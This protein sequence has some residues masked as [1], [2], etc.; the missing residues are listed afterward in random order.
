MQRLKL[1]LFIALAACFF[2]TPGLLLGQGASGEP[3]APFVKAVEV[4]GNKAISSE[5]ILARIKTRAG[6]PYY[7]QSGRDDI[8]RLY[9]TGYFSDISIDI[10]E[11]ADGLRVIF[12]VEERPTIQEVTIKGV[13]RVS[14][15]GL[16]RK[17][18][19]KEGQYL[20]LAYLK[21][22][23]AAIKKE[24]ESKGLVDTEVGHTIELDEETNKAVVTIQVTEGAR[25][26]IRRVY[27]DGNLHFSNGRIMGLIKTRPKTWWLLRPGY[28]KEEQLNED[29]ERIKAFYLQNGY[30]DAQVDYPTRTGGS[31]CAYASMKA[32][33][34]RSAVSPSR[35]PRSSRPRRCART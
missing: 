6:Q 4:E 20:N 18:R 23:L 27:V 22:D 11:E 15:R 17:L 14:R 24:Y 31:T 8:K 32:S 29:L 30:L 12:R 1:H 26:A 16:K 13:R 35:G 9:E 25:Q 34:T 28:F 7:P 21:E 19:T 10:K 3:D 2:L 33:I 5:T